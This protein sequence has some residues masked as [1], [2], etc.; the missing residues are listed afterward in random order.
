MAGSFRELWIVMGYENEGAD[1]L[2]VEYP[3]KRITQSA[4]CRGCRAADVSGLP[5]RAPPLFLKIE[6]MA[7]LY[8]VKACLIRPRYQPRRETCHIFASP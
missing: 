8:A 6:R 4:R 3:S 7:R 1:R 5:Q 2:S